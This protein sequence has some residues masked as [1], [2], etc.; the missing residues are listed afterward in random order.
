MRDATGAAVRWLGH[1]DE[2]VVVGPRGDAVTRQ[3]HTYRSP[4]LPPLLGFTNTSRG[5]V[6]GRGLIWKAERVKAEIPGT[7]WP[8]AAGGGPTCSPCPSTVVE[9]N[10]KLCPSSGLVPAGDSL[11]DLR[12]WDCRSCGTQRGRVGGL[13]GWGSGRGA[14]GQGRDRGVWGQGGHAPEPP[15]RCRKAA[16]CGPAEGPHRTPASRGRHICCGAEGGNV[17]GVTPRCQPPL[18]PRPFPL[19][20]TWHQTQCRPVMPW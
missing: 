8:A 11:S 3:G 19:T 9:L 14:W 1:P 2:L 15:G 7:A 6:P 10:L 17:S 20:V 4:C 12:Q 13:R 5:C 18:A 16:G